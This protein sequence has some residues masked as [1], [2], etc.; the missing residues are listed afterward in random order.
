MQTFLGTATLIWGPDSTNLGTEPRS[1]K[2]SVGNMN[3]AYLGTG[4]VYLGDRGNNFDYFGD[5]GPE[6]TILGTASL[7]EDWRTVGGSEEAWRRIGGGLDED[8]MRIG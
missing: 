6:P 5:R 3:W 8:W 1:P 2:K 7:G 4:I